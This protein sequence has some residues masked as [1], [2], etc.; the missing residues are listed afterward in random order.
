MSAKPQ[1]TCGCR[2]YR[3]MYR[4]GCSYSDPYK[5]SRTCGET[6]TGTGRHYRYCPG[7]EETITK[8]H[9]DKYCD[10]P[11]HQRLRF[12]DRDWKCCNCELDY[13]MR[14]ECDNCSHGCCKNC[15][16]GRAQD[17]SARKYSLQFL[18]DIRSQDP[19]STPSP[20]VSPLVSLSAGAQRRL[21]GPYPGLPARDFHSTLINPFV[22]E[23]SQRP[24]PGPTSIISRPSTTIQ[25]RPHGP[26]SGLCLRRSSPVVSQPSTISM[27]QARP[28][29]QQAGSHSNSNIRRPQNSDEAPSSSSSGRS[30]TTI[31]KESSLGSDRSLTTI[32]QSRSQSPL[33]N[34]SSRGGAPS[35]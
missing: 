21:Q 19:V 7:V 10:K 24:H 25:T 28:Q 8:Y 35:L 34:T 31:T 22:Q 23:R 3:V 5:N 32:T 17:V 30:P 15:T 18:T 16:Q 1:H 13:Q 33:S 29:R 6:K 14:D 26:D 12:V 4:C 11:H 2:K 27:R 20:S 9:I